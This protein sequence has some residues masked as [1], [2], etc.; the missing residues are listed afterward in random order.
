MQGV[1]EG[2]D[3]GARVQG[4]E[5]DSANWHFECSERYYSIEIQG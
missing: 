5:V 2:G 4:Q 1:E 3:V